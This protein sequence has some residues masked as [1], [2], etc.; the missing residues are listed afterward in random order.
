MK[1]YYAK[2]FLLITLLMSVCALAYQTIQKGQIYSAIE[3][4]F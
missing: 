3:S 4:K 2:N 1:Q